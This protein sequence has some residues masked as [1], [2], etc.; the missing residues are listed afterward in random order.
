[1]MAP[2]EPYATRVFEWDPTKTISKHDCNSWMQVSI[3]IIIVLA[4]SLSN[5]VSI[6]HTSVI[7]GVHE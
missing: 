2:D 7:K 3:D 6:T 1:M 4:C 5:T